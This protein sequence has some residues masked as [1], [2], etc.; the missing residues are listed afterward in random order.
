MGSYV[1][2]ARKDRVETGFLET[3]LHMQH[4]D[5]IDRH[6]GHKEERNACRVNRCGSG[7]IDEA[8]QRGSDDD[9]RLRSC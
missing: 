6:A 7:D 4:A 1:A 8:T 9:C 3:T 2:N 5:E